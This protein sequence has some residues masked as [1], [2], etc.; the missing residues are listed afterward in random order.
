MF[1]LDFLLEMISVI[2]TP[3]AGYVIGNHE[4]ANRIR[5]VGRWGG[6]LALICSHG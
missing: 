3:Q 1:D 2:P 5:A 6:D 4:T